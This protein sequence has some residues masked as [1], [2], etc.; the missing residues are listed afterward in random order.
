M[1]FGA[2]SGT[3]RIVGRFFE[4]ELKSVRTRVAERRD[5]RAPHDERYEIYQ[6]QA[7]ARGGFSRAPKSQLLLASGL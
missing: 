1:T 4:L 7:G 3:S 6:I 5:L 2:G